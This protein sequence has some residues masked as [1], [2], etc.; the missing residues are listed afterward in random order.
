MPVAEFKRGMDVTDARIETMDA[1]ASLLCYGDSKGCVY[2]KQFTLF[3]DQFACQDV[4]SLKAIKNFS[5]IGVKIKNRQ[6]R[7][8]ADD[9]SH[10]SLDEW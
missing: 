1:F 7:D 6:N 9:E 10:Y 8:L 3:D 5:L 4:K 2:I